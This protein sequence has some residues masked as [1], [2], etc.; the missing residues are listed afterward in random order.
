VSSATGSYRLRVGSCFGPRSVCVRPKA[1]TLNCDL[2]R[3]IRVACLGVALSALAAAPIASRADTVA[4]LLGNFTINQYCG[5]RLAEDSVAVR[6]T[7][8]FG[9]LPALRELHAADANGDGVTTQEERDAY[10]ARLAPEF[11][12]R[13]K[14]TVDGAPVPLKVTHWTTSLPTEQGGFS[15]RLDVDFDGVLPPAAANGDHTLKFANQNYAGRFGWQEIVVEAASPLKVFATNAFST[16]LTGGL[17]QSLSAMPAAGPLNERSASLS[18]TRGATPPGALLL[19]PRPG[20]V[21]TPSQAA[22]PMPGNAN[23]SWLLRETR[24]VI[25]LIS[26]PDL[27]PQVALF[28]LLAAMFLGALH[29]FSPGHGKTVVGAYLI[30]SR[31]TPRHAAFLGATV[32]ITHT[33]GV[34]AIGFATLFAS[35]FIVPERLFPVLSLLSGLLVLG[36][37]AVLLAQRWR[38][39][40]DALKKLPQ[41]K[42]TQRAD[43]TPTTAFHPLAEAAH[44]GASGRGFIATY[45]DARHQHVHAYSQH[46][47]HHHGH[48]AGHTHGS[49][50][51]HSHGG[52]M[53]SH[54]PPGATGERVTW[55]GL[56]ALGIAGGLVPCPS[57]MVLLLAAVALNKTAYGLVL[58]LAFSVGLALTLTAV[59]LAFLYARNRIRRP[60]AGSRWPQLLPVLSALA[61][62]LVGALLCYGAVTG[63][64]F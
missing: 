43:L 39:A 49:T 4:S 30:G 19:Q 57:A 52:R 46:H 12:E 62:T 64:Q 59:G 15:L 27:A 36:M 9:Q 18:F 21:P 35:R 34:F 1:R 13:L 33:L 26:T 56:L 48:L 14:L 23:G 58:V 22:A 2:L 28:A 16:S 61:I 53:H 20:A 40:R 6:Y 29:A 24:H 8:V 60:A 37:G 44:A 7:V 17:T 11:A 63:A 41:K 31:G 3:Q 5:L 50:A 25:S 47:E 42:Y 55:R 38:A 54:L 10:V 51:V 45:A 32:T